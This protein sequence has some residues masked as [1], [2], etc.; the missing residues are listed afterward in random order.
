M[1]VLSIPFLVRDGD[2]LP[3]A[4]L[5][6]DGDSLPLAPPPAAPFFMLVFE[7]TGLL[8]PLPLSLT[9][10]FLSTA[11][12]GKSSDFSVETSAATLTASESLIFF[13][14]CPPCRKVNQKEK[15][16]EL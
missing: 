1:K 9:H 3:N 2:L 4:F 16:I 6:G 12:E 14:D 13:S 8:P 5:V 10:S 15:R 7:G 11:K